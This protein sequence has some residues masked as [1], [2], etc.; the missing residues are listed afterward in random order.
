MMQGIEPAD[1]NHRRGPVAVLPF[2]PDV[3]RP[4]AVEVLE[5]GH[6]HPAA[7]YAHHAHRF[8]EVLLCRRG[9]GSHRVGR[10]EHPL[11][12]GTLHLVGAGTPHSL[13]LSA[14]AQCVLVLFEADVLAEHGDGGP[15]A[16][17]G[18]PLLRPFVDD[19]VLSL[20]PS[21]LLRLEARIDQLGA[22]AEA[23]R[24]F[25]DD[26]VRALL[27][28][29]LIDIARLAPAPPAPATDGTVAAALGLIDARFRRLL[30]LSEVA[31][32]LHRD[33]GRLTSAV[34]AATGRTV[35]QW[36]EERRMAE[37][38]HLLRATDLTVAAIGAQV[39]FPDDGYFGR[40]FT[41]LH[42]ISPGR[43]RALQR[44]APIVR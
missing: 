36:I 37:A 22:E 38:R 20:T 25:A 14:D 2:R 24:G 12:A 44:G 23:H 32:A 28:L 9:R 3:G 15:I 43:W 17:L 31:A 6:R 16:V 33:P 29:L 8:H 5:L 10:G 7:E 27:R 19:A 40:R 18:D 4:V 11:W 39:G 21:D 13:Q 34:R 26:A 42:G 30:T 35:R 1:A 41:R